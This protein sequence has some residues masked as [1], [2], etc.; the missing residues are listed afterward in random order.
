MWLWIIVALICLLLLIVLILC[1]PVDL[2][3]SF[4]INES[5]A[6]KVRL[7][8]FFGWIDTELRRKNDTSEKKKL[9]AKAT[10]KQ[11]QRIRV[12]TVYRILKMRGLWSQF[13]RLI[14]GIFKSLKV[15]ELT[16]HLKLGLE[17]PA[18]IDEAENKK[19][20]GGNNDGNPISKIN[21][22]CKKIQP[23]SGNCEAIRHLGHFD[24]CGS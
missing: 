5:P 12:R 13:T 17:N 7:L 24:Q 18:E 1:I 19:H 23:A 10:K 2:V 3:F 6:Y 4:T 8:W 20:T 11:R 9:A 14:S 21:I 16:A 22:I 15:K